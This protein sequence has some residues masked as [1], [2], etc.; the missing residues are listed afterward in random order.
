MTAFAPS[1]QAPDPSEVLRQFAAEVLAEVPKRFGTSDLQ[2]EASQL[3][4]QALE[5]GSAG[6]LRTE[7]SLVLLDRLAQVC[8]VGGWQRVLTKY[9]LDFPTYNFVEDY[10]TNAT[11]PWVQPPPI[12]PG[13]GTRRWRVLGQWLGFPLGVPASPLTANSLWIDFL[14]RQ[15]FNILTYKT[16]RSRSQEPHPSPNWVFVDDDRPWPVG[17]EHQMVV[18]DVKTWPRDHRAFSTAN[19]FGMPSSDPTVWQK[20]VVSTLA[21]LEDDQLLIV[22]VVGSQRAGEDQVQDFVTVAKQAEETGCRVIELN[23]SCPN[24]IDEETGEVSHDFICLSHTATRTVVQAV[25]NGLVHSDTR[26]VV[27]LAYLDN[28]TL[29]RVVTPIAH[30]VDGI[31]GINTMQRRVVDVN[32]MPTFGAHRRD[33]GVSGIAIREHGLDF[34]RRLADLRADLDGNFDIL[35]MGGVMTPEDV[36]QFHSA[37]ANAVLSATAP[38]MNARFAGEVIRSLGHV[39]PDR[40]GGPQPTSRYSR[41]SALSEPAVDLVDAKAIIEALAHTPEQNIDRLRRASRLA[42]DRF[43]TALAAAAANGLISIRRRIG[44]EVEAVLTPTGEAVLASVV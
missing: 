23:L 24:S 36:L 38:F 2:A 8:F 39:L 32:G 14:A 20:D 35:G 22:S 28:E 16:V 25:R 7:D 34:V 18:G 19:S 44:G 29:E 13:A 6:Q 11:Q 4:R 10:A 12:R 26:L 42:G 41:A 15:G 9:G 3:A 30:M 33:A 17:E 1:F 37:G 31:S 5:R 27:K 43:E 21:A 40:P